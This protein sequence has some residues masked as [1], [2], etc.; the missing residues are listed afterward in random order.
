MERV[1]K[2]QVGEVKSEQIANGCEE[3]TSLSVL[4]NCVC[5]LR[6]EFE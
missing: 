1:V 3:T 4:T 2:D 5:V 6:R